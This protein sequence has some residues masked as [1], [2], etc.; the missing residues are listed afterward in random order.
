[1]GA[2][3]PGAFGFLSPEQESVYFAPNLWFDFTL[4]GFGIPVPDGN[5]G[6]V[7]QPLTAEEAE[8]EWIRQF[9][10][11]IGN[12]NKPIVLLPWHDYGPT[13]FNNDGYSESMFTSLIREAYNS[14]A[15]FVTLDDASQ[16]IQA[17]EQSQ[18][19]VETTGN[20]ITANVVASNVGDFASRSRCG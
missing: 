19:F 6:F 2:G 17:F 14:G 8:A 20:T 3:Y 18:L 16:R 10:E 5:G 15:E 4:I 11:V 7:P 1:M 12:S 9:N 13:N